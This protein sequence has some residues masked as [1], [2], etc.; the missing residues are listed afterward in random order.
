MEIERIIKPTFSVIG[1][2]GSTR[3][4]IGFVQDLW[5]AANAH[6]EQIAGL[7]KRDEAGVPVGFGAL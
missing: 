6:F 4:G 1:R 7:V 3:D 2:E 5:A